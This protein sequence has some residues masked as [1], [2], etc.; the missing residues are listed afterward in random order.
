MRAIL[1]YNISV[2]LYLLILILYI[3][4]ISFYNLFS[5]LKFSLET[6]FKNNNL[7]YKLF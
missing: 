5:Y 6:I 3:L 2:F 7:Q 4:Y 1:S